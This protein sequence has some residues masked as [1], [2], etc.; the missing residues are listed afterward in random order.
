MKTEKTKSR[1][2]ASIIRAALTV[3]ACLLCC[4]PA[5]GR[6]R[7]RTPTIDP[8][9]GGKQVITTTDWE[10]EDVIE[11]K[12]LDREGK[13]LRKEVK[14]ISPSG[15]LIDDESYN[16]RGNVKSKRRTITD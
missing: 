1:T 9:A 3:Y 6:G 5:A 14:T 7:T 11:T 4:L 16:S 8:A 15:V 12:H 10:D 13:L 2:T